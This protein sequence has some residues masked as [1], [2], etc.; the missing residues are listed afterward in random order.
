VPLA[1]PSTTRADSDAGSLP[2]KKTIKLL[3]LKFSSEK[4]LEI[5]F[6]SVKPHFPVLQTL[7]SR[8]FSGGKVGIYA[9]ADGS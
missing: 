5:P 2:L 9:F 4:H 8:G 6:S 7:F 1:N 3:K